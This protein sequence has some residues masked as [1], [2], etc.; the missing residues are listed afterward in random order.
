MKVLLRERKEAQL[1]GNWR[2]GTLVIRDY[3]RAT[4]LI[5][6]STGHLTS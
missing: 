6:V 4:V 2:F 5:S 3:G 1:N